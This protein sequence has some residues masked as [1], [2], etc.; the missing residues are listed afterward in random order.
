ML[1]PSGKIRSFAPPSE[2]EAFFAEFAKLLARYPGAAE[3]YAIVERAAVTGARHLIFWECTDVGGFV[4]CIP[5]VQE[6]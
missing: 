2:H 5:K 4:D 3:R 1:E 6:Q